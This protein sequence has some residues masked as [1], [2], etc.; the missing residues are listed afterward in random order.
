MAHG[1]QRLRPSVLRRVRQ[2]QQTLRQRCAAHGQRMVADHRELLRQPAEH[3]IRQGRRLEAHHRGSPMHR[4][5]CSFD[6]GPV[7]MPEQLVAEADSQH[8]RAPAVG[9]Q[10]RRHA[11]GRI[12]RRVPG[13]RRQQHGTEAGD[14]DPGAEGAD[15]RRHGAQ[16]LQH[17]H[18]VPREAVV[19]INDQHPGAPGGG[20]RRLDVSIHELLCGGHGRGGAA[21]DDDHGLGAAR[22]RGQGER[23]GRAKSG[24]WGGRPSAD[25]DVT[26]RAP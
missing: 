14:V 19:M 25:R 1:H 21:D 13:A 2:G 16:L 7:D 11:D 9:Q 10:R 15:Q 26:R 4:T 12:L 22:G 5:R 20:T 8:G 3:R 6:L 24:G 23:Q 17:V 18:Q